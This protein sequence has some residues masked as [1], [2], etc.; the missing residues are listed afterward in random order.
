MLK[1]K[2]YEIIFYDVI[3]QDEVEPPITLKPDIEIDQYQDEAFY[4][5]ENTSK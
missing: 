4:L 1:N 2:H 3:L 5:I